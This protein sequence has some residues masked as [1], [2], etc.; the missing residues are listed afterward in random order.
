L[1][2]L[3][4]VTSGIITDISKL[5]FALKVTTTVS[6]TSI[7]PG[8]TTA[9]WKLVLNLLAFLRA[10]I[11]GALAAHESTAHEDIEAILVITLLKGFGGTRYTQ[12]P[13]C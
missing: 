7:W 8:S 3:A 5:A 6:C 13:T 2:I 11:H 10:E 4:N 12:K 1:H 9:R